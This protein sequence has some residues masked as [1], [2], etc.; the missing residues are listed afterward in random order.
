[1][2]I[3]PITQYNY[4]K[5][6]NYNYM[7]TFCARTRPNFSELVRGINQTFEKKVERIQGNIFNINKSEFQGYTFEMLEKKINNIKNNLKKIKNKQFIA[8][9]K[10]IE[11]NGRNIDLADKILRNDSLYLNKNIVLQFKSILKVTKTPD[12][13]E[14]K[15]IIIKKVLNSKLLKNNDKIQS[16]IGDI[17]YFTNNTEQARARVKVM[18]CYEQI[19]KSGKDNA[20]AGDIITYTHSLPASDVANSILQSRWLERNPYI[21]DCVGDILDTAENPKSAKILKVFFANPNLYR[22]ITLLKN[23][24]KIA[25]QEINLFDGNVLESSDEVIKKSII[26]HLKNRE[27]KF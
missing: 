9:F 27:Y 5:N 4:N 16:N 17:L 3:S 14:A 19:L 24:E 15:F 12:E 1:M 23:C 25:S 13:A 7:P 6:N 8:A 22:N 26:N 2:Y 20:L 10:E 18:D 21:N 11:L